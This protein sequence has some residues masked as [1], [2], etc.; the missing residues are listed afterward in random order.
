MLLMWTP[1]RPGRPFIAHARALSPGPGF[2]GS[3]DMKSVRRV[4]ALTCAAGLALS[5]AAAHA[6]YGFVTNIAGTFNDISATGAVITSGD[7]AS[8]AFISGVTNAVVTTSSLFACTNGFVS[9]PGSSTFTNTPL[10]MSGQTLV[11][12]PYWDDLFVDAPGTLKH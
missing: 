6:Q 12:S 4:R 2:C 11:L 7:D 5:A 1:R 10:P 3:D 9:T 8:A